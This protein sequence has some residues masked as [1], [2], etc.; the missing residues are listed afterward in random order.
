MGRV[1]FFFTIVFLTEN[2]SHIY[3]NN[4]VCQVWLRSEYIK[5]TA[6]NLRSAG[7]IRPTKTSGHGPF[8]TA[9]FGGFGLCV[10]VLGSDCNNRFPNTNHNQGL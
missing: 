8:S 2:E 5:P 3:P 10:E 9:S 1:K 6:G 7:Q 4:N